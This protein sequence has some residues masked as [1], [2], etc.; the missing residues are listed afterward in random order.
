MDLGTDAFDALNKAGYHA[1]KSPEVLDNWLNSPAIVLNKYEVRTD[2]SNPSGKIPNGKMLG[3]F[4]SVNRTPYRELVEEFIRL[5]KTKAIKSNTLSQ[6][7]LIIGDLY[8]LF[9]LDFLKYSKVNFTLVIERETVNIDNDKLKSLL[10]IRAHD[11][12]FLK[13]F[14]AALGDET[15]Q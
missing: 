13:S 4:K 6:L 11:D 9:G 8:K 2:G 10:K 5:K 7:A 12:A 1:T 14:I 3:L 15:L